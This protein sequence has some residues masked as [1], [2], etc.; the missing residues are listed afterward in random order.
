MILKKIATDDC[1]QAWSSRNDRV[2]GVLQLVLPIILIQYLVFLSSISRV[3]LFQGL[4]YGKET[5]RKKRSQLVINEVKWRLQSKPDLEHWS[6][7]SKRTRPKI[8]YK[9]ITAGWT[10]GDQ[11]HHAVEEKWEIHGKRTMGQRSESLRGFYDSRK[12]ASTS[13]SM[14]YCR[15][16]RNKW[17]IN[18]TAK[19]IVISNLFDLDSFS[20]LYPD[21]FFVCRCLRKVI[22]FSVR[23]E[24]SSTRKIFRNLRIGPENVTWPHEW[25]HP[26]NRGVV[27][28]DGLVVMRWDFRLMVSGFVTGSVLQAKYF[29]TGLPQRS[30]RKHVQHGREAELSTHQW[31]YCRSIYR[32]SPIL[33]VCCIQSNSE[34]VVERTGRREDG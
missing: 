3:L 13:F 15:K 33:S 25:D 31:S 12:R 29:P 7:F 19:G 6:I 30:R 26:V 11:F 21:S 10:H 5:S 2:G 20:Q 32:L 1:L 24:Q 27:G 16:H 9:F 14:T 22:T 34:G 28:Q 4:R 8:R 17:L 23:I 18:S